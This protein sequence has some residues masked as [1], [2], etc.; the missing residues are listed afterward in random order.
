M[1]QHSG[2]YYGVWLTRIILAVWGILFL[3]L[4]IVYR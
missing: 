4:L 1:K 2:Q 3:T